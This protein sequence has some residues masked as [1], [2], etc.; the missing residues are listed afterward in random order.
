[1][2]LINIMMAGAMVACSACSESEYELKNLVPDEYKKIMY[3]NQSGKQ[4]LTLFDTEEDN[5]YSFSVYKGGSEPDQTAGVELGVMTQEAV[6][7]AY[8]NV[9]GVKYKII[10]AGSY[11]L[12]ATRL[13]FSTADRYK[14]VT[15]SLK[16][17]AIKAEM[18]SDPT[19]VWVLPIQATS[20][21]DSVNSSKNVVFLQIDGVI[22][23]TM[24]FS[25]V[26]PEVKQYEYGKVP[27]ISENI[28]IGLDTENRWNLT[29]KLAVDA[30]YLA[31][32]NT[33]NGTVYQLMPEG[34]YTVPE[35]M[36]LKSGITNSA[37]NVKVSGSK[38]NPGDYMLPIRIAEISQFAISKTNNVYPLAVRVMAP[39]LSR[40][41][42]T[43][44][45][46]TEELTGEGNSGKA[47]CLI[48]GDPAT[49]WHSMWQSGTNPGMPY[50]I[51][52]D[53][54]KEQTF[55]QVAMA[56]RQNTSYT[57]TGTGKFYVSTDK[58]NWTLAGSFKMQKV[59]DLQT[60]G[61]IPT[62]GRYLK[63]VIE[64]SNRD[65]NA[66]LSEVY[67]YGL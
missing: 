16:P 24:G 64:T 5:T 19:A 37:I 54:K 33:K 32:Y 44:E 59:L 56:Q 60:F 42:W 34:D 58:S 65:T 8:S 39:E 27:D 23:P 63:I 25:T 53:T 36:T 38:F 62:K 46:N 9:E 57:D 3:I 28:G 49:Y 20:K 1:M 10:D 41:G 14:I 12:D 45:A 30:D 50:A 26:E 29:C 13:D 66:S 7:A 55:Y 35:E 2:K 21:T 61:L 47:S 22:M 48:D 6:D 15:V 31:S 11:E 43:A 40:D 18:E 4:E 52:L 67:A 17:Q 51:I